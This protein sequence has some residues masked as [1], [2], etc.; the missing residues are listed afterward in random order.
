MATP[1]PCDQPV[2]PLPTP[3]CMGFDLIRFGRQDRVFVRGSE[4]IY[5][6][7][8]ASFDGMNPLSI[9]Y[10]GEPERVSR[11]LDL[12]RDGFVYTGEAAV[13]VLENLD[14]AK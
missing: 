3:L 8:V 1:A 7:C 14:I 5:I 11:S 6:F 2:R 9:A 12:G 13:L 10:N 4:N